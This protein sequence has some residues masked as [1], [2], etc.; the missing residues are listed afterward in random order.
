MNYGWSTKQI[1]MCW[2]AI[3][4]GNLTAVLTFQANN[5]GV[6]EKEPLP[7]S[8]CTLKINTHHCTNGTSEK[9][10]LNR[11]K[12]FCSSVFW[13]EFN[14]KWFVRF[15]KILLSRLGPNHHTPKANCE[16]LNLKVPP[17]QDV[18]QQNY[19]NLLFLDMSRSYWCLVWGNGGSCMTISSY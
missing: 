6:S 17:V 5:S 10:R 12:G 4:S 1:S 19:F 2:S 3:I 15:V 13:A 14:L 8:Y 18:R 7:V 9:H 16:M 11:S